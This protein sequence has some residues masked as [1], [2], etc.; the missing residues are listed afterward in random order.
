MALPVNINDR[1]QDK[2]EAGPLGE[3]RVRVSSIGTVTGEF[4]T[5]GLKIAGRISVVTI[6]DA[7]WTALPLVALTN[8]NAILI[9]NQTSVQAKINYDNTE[10]GY[11]GIWINGNGE[12]YRD[13]KDTILIY[14]KCYTGSI[15][16][17]IEELS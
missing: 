9:Q 2:F 10:P 8:R 17:V 16:L 5:S 6:N 7:T 15:D 11:V 14:A 12:L 1:E 3:T 13:I 4:T